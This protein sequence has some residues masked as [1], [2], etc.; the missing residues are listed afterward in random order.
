MTL[1]V[2]FQ[3]QSIKLGPSNL[4]YFNTSITVGNIIKAFKTIENISA[5]S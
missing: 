2:F 5:I 4:E 3:L 1:T